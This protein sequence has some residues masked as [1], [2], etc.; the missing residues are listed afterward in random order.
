MALDCVIGHPSQECLDSPPSASPPREKP[1]WQ[2]LGRL[3]FVGRMRLGIPGYGHMASRARHLNQQFGLSSIRP[4]ARLRGA[5]NRDRL[6]VNRA[7]PRLA[8]QRPVQRWR[9]TGGVVEIVCAKFA[10]VSR[11][12]GADI[13]ANSLY[14]S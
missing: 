9:L 10:K 5:Q 7:E 13:F 4:A 11:S 3:F 14:T 2:P 8:P 12:V 6:V 1:A